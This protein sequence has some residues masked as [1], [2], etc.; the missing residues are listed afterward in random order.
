VPV[1]VTIGPLQSKEEAIK[2]FFLGGMDNVHLVV[3]REYGQPLFPAK[4]FCRSE[5]IDFQTGE[6]E[7]RGGNLFYD[8]WDYQL[9]S[10]PAPASKPKSDR[11]P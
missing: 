11:L 10:E 5:P 4:I 2:W 7:W 9:K 3:N 1:D 6:V 8:Q